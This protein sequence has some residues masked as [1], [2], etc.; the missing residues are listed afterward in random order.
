MYNGAGVQSTVAVLGLATN[1]GHRQRPQGSPPPPEHWP[2]KKSGRGQRL[3]LIG[4][5]HWRC[6]YRFCGGGEGAA[7]PGCA[8]TSL[9]GRRKM[10]PGRILS[11]SCCDGGDTSGSEN[12]TRLV[13]AGPPG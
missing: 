7:G 5:F 2:Q 11:C 12:E 8:K 3:I 13:S 6:G 1:Q 4:G 9:R 10:V